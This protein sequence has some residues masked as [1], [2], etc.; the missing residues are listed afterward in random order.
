MQIFD[1]FGTPRLRGESHGEALR[2]PITEAL[3]RWEAATMA[4]LGARAPADI[5]RYCADFLSTTQLM[6][7]AE[8]ETPDLVTELRGI[9]AGAGQDFARIAVYNLMDEQWWH[10]AVAKAPPPGCSL[11]AQKVPG[12]HVLAQNM[13]LPAHMEGSQVALRLGGADASDAVLEVFEYTGTRAKTSTLIKLPRTK[14]AVTNGGA[15]STAWSHRRAPESCFFS[16]SSIA[17]PA[18]ACT[19]VSSAFSQPPAA[20]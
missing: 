4:G 15:S 18:V 2:G 5:D 1:C 8:A 17:C 7:R 20:A 9:A 11:I 16:A 10:D 6:Q 3:M 14:I 19:S 12:G 13:D